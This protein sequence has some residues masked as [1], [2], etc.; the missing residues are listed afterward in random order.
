MILLPVV[1]FLFATL[2]AAHRVKGPIWAAAIAWLISILPVA[3]GA[4]TFSYLE[5]RAY[6]YSI[7]LITYIG[8]FVAGSV[9]FYLVPRRIAPVVPLG[10]PTP[11]SLRRS[12][13]LVW[14]CW[15]IG[16]AGAAFVVVDFYV[17]GGAGLSDLAAL[18]DTYVGKTSA[19][20][21]AQIGSVL[22]W[23]C[24]YC[25]IFALLYRRRLSRIRQAI[26]MMPIGGYFLISVL[27]AGRQA[28]FQVMLVTL[29]T[30]IIAATRTRLRR[31]GQATLART[32]GGSSKLLIAGVSAAMIS[33]MG[34]VAVARNDSVIS[35]DKTEVLVTLF[36]FH[37]SPAL[38][39]VG[40]FVGQSIRSVMV[41]ALIYFSGS[42][43]IFQKFLTLHFEPAYGAMSLPLFFRQVQGLTGLS[44]SD[45]AM[46]RADSLNALGVIGAGW[47]TAISSYLIDFGSV[48][49]GVLLLLMGYYSAF[50][51][52][53]ALTSNRFED[54]VIGILV[55]LS[56]IYMPLTPAISDNNLLL[57]WGFCLLISFMR[58]NRHAP[59]R[60]TPQ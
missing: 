44:P 54:I 49:T 60:I 15:W 42:I 9:A 10:E 12:L 28:A 21:Y 18:R 36:D 26:I 58:Q 7:I 23:A 22:T 56:A 40:D 48:G 57:L 45:V 6:S 19:S 47:T 34:Y 31:L 43:A 35:D 25:F 5:D 29:L 37:M 46:V 3:T 4:L 53:R 14:L 52:T 8:L 1:F 41:E 55:M 13:K 30:V 11:A 38:V 32:R 59:V 33:Y 50:A 27:S 17:S 20:I 2:V 39:A 16:I 24:L 51:W